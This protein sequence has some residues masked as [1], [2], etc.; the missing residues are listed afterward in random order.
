MI[1]KINIIG[2]GGELSI[3]FLCSF[4]D[5]KSIDSSTLYSILLKL[6]AEKYKKHNRFSCF[7]RRN[8]QT[9]FRKH[10]QK[11]LLKMASLVLS[12]K[13]D[14][15][16]YLLNSRNYASTDNQKEEAL[17]KYIR[18]RLKDKNNYLEI[19]QTFFV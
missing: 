7:V 19:N 15:M 4:N 6:T 18:G 2:E 3:E 8:S 13:A 1:Q 11:P 5:C 9:R 10:D 16:S 17:L 14:P 12:T